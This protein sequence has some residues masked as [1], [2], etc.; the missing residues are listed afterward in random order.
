M[1][2]FSYMFGGSGGEAKKEL[3][4]KAIADMRVQI[5]MLQKKEKHLEQQIQEQT[6]IARENV[7]TNKNRKYIV[8]V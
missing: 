2:F 4:K 1:S 3:P 5:D 6:N 8:L 7:K